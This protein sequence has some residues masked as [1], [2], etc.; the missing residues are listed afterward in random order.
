MSTGQQIR[1]LTTAD[2]AR[3]AYSAVGSGA[4][5]VR[6]P[7]WLSHLDLEWKIPAIRSF[8]EQLA[9]SHTVVRYDSQ[10]CGLSDRDRDDFSIAAEVK[11]LELVLDSLDLERVT[12][13]GYGAGGPVAVSYA[14]SHPERVSSLILFGTLGDH[15]HAQLSEELPE[16]V[17]AL[18]IDHW[19]LAARLFAALQAPD[20][21]GA[22]LQL[23]ADMYFHSSSGDNVVRAVHS[24]LHGVELLDQLPKLT[25]PTTVIHR[26]DD[27]TIPYQAGRELAARI[28]VSC[29][30]PLEGGSHLPFLGNSDP[31]I[32]V[33]TRALGDDR[34]DRSGVESPD[35]SRQLE[36]M[37]RNGGV[38]PCVNVESA[39]TAT[40]VAESSGALFMREGEYWTITY[41]A[42]TFR[43]RD[44]RGLK[45]IAQLL[46]HPGREFHANELE[47]RSET[48]DACLLSSLEP[49]EVSEEELADAGL[50]CDSAGDA[51]EMLDSHAKQA[52]RRRMRELR[53][54]LIAAESGGDATRAT[55][56]EE[57]ISFLTRELSRA[58]GLGG[59]DRRAASMAQRSRVNVTRAIRRTI[60][61]IRPHSPGLAGLLA[62]R[63]KTGL[64]CAYRSDDGPPMSWNL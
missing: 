23:L 40:E 44:A 48:G 34:S 33:I 8:F 60:E 19:P 64:L 29:F 36:A 14:L 30:V 56:I 31:V 57:E 6:T 62:Q 22:T 4:A 39:P 2:G 7:P 58:V 47:V 50:H 11:L 55:A 21:D 1:F 54:D 43:L 18:A 12:L 27:P 32:S 37:E 61:K 49:A 28:P 52:Y 26:L 10:G 42:E 51:G 35:S 41:A 38:K 25:V 13:F 63:I 45:Y 16:A 9:R 20:A 3:I 5:V 53:E 17:Q 24:L 59:R 46:R 15:R